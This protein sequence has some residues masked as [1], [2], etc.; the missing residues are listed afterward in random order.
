MSGKLVIV[1][2]GGNLQA[3]RATPNYKVGG[4]VVV[5]DHDNMEHAGISSDQADE[6]EARELK[7]CT[8]ML[9]F[10]IPDEQAKAE[11]RKEDTDG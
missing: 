4:A 3:L 6:I 7:P 1:I 5:V 8:S 2:S 11:G 10:D 9:G